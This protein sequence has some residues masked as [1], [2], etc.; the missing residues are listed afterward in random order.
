MLSHAGMNLPVWSQGPLKCGPAAATLHHDGLVIIC[1][2]PLQ[3][4]NQSFTIIQAFTGHMMKSF[5]AK[6]HQQ[7]E[8][9]TE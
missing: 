3:L 6:C 1:V 9:T 4:Q 2:R 7:A 5:Q 8:I